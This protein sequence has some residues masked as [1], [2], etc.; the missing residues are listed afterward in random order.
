MDAK[1]ASGK[2]DEN[3]QEL[4]AALAGRP[5]LTQRLLVIAKLAHE[6]EQTGRIRSA[7]EMEALLIAAVRKLGNETLE[8]WGE[9]VDKV[10]GQALKAEV[11]GTHLREKKR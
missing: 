11:G 1:M 6:P 8:S 10:V 7:H 2:D 5:E 4:I 3:L 9:G